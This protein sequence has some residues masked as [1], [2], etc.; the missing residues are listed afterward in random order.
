MEDNAVKKIVQ[1]MIVTL[2]QIHEF[3][4]LYQIKQEKCEDTQY[5]INIRNSMER[6]GNTKK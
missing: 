3:Q 6:K 4:Q 5:V 1:P 2:K